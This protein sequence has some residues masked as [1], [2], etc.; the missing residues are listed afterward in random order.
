MMIIFVADIGDWFSNGLRWGHEHAGW[1][2]GI[3]LA[4]TVAIFLLAG[5]AGL[6]PALTKLGSL[7]YLVISLGLSAATMIALGNLGA[8]GLGGDSFEDPSAPQVRMILVSGANAGEL[9]VEIRHFN[10]EPPSTERWT[11]STTLSTGIA[12]IADRCTA[13]FNGEK[14]LQVQFHETPEQLRHLLIEEFR[15]KRIRLV[16]EIPPK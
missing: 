13:R 11:S 6:L 15:L 5:P 3:T 9:N 10:D 2:A 1:A 16:E 7:F 4:T 14:T 8:G 12:N